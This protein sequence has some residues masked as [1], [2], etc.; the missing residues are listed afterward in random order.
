MA[1]LAIFHY[2]QQIGSDPA[3]VLFAGKADSVTVYVGGA[4]VQPVL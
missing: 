4:R 3:A 2:G 1:D